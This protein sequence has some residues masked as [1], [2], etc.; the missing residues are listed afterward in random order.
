MKR[1][2]LRSRDDLAVFVSL[3]A[4]VGILVSATVAMWVWS[5]VSDAPVAITV[6]KGLGIP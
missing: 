4:A 2:Q 1:H 5:V 6:E 3:T